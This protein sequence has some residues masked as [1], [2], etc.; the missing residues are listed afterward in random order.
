[1]CVIFHWTQPLAGNC[2]ILTTTKH[3]FL[4]F[5]FWLFVFSFSKFGS[6][7]ASFLVCPVFHFVF[8]F[9]TFVIPVHFV[10]LFVCLL[11][12]SWFV[13]FA[14][15]GTTTTLWVKWLPF[16]FI[17]ASVIPNQLIIDHYSKRRCHWHFCS[18]AKERIRQSTAMSTTCPP[19]RTNCKDTSAT[20]YMLLPLAAK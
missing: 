14:V 3:L 20:S 10:C 15:Y 5:L 4:L 2:S 17:C 7:P 1:M 6:I 13:L 8:L 12:P 18:C 9:F 19:R 11:I 16:F